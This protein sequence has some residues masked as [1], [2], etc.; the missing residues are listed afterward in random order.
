MSNVIKQKRFKKTICIDIDGTVCK[1]TKGDYE[2]TEPFDDAR[3]AV[4]RLYDEGFEIVFFT[5]RNNE[6]VEKVYRQG[7]LMT[8][9]Q[10]KKWGFKFHKLYM[11]KPSHHILVDDKAL[12]F[13]QDWQK[14]YKEIK[15]KE[16]DDIY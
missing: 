2:N 4:N 5:G 13:K 6:D 14:I 9:N 16:N 3:K 15:D 7:Y 1:Q 12:F 10:L 11:G 8:M